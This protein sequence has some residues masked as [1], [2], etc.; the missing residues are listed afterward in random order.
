MHTKIKEIRKR[1]GL[2]QFTACAR[3]LEVLPGEGISP[4][5]LARLEDEGIMPT[6]P[7]VVVAALLAIYNDELELQG[8]DRIKLEDLGDPV[9][10]EKAQR[11][12]DLLSRASAC[13]HGIAA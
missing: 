3:L 2:S 9:L 12:L 7:Q 10:I 5:T 6:H 11:T 8:S 1:A 4:K 13:I